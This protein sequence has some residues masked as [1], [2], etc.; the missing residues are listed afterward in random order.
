VDGQAA[1]S[2]STRNKRKGG[3]AK[4]PSP[5]RAKRKKFMG[6]N[7]Q[8]SL[9]TGSTTKLAAMSSRKI[10]ENHAISNKKAKTEKLLESDDK[11]A[12]AWLEEAY[13]RK[14]LPGKHVAMGSSK[15]EE[16]QNGTSE[17]EADTSQLVHDTTVKKGRHRQK[18]VHD[19]PPDETKEQRDARTVFFGNIPI[20]VAKSK[21][22]YTRALSP[23]WSYLSHKQSV[24]S[25]GF[26][27]AY[28]FT[29]PRS[30]DR[31]HALPLR[32]IPK[33]DIRCT[34]A[35]RTQP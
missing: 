26:Q 35:T 24:S 7:E 6:D 10:K 14:V 33:A 13:E 16:H 17:S 22:Q 5:T 15:N 1:A 11:E 8:L 4:A 2:N 31:V 18:H 12:D 25:E 3:I 9:P 30:Q 34:W 29:R 28:T 21:V 27:A 32:G 19:V 23:S 20:E